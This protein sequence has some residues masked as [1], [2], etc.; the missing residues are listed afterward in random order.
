MYY[1]DNTHDFLY[2][3]LYSIFIYYVLYLYYV[4]LHPGS[5]NRPQ[6]GHLGRLAAFALSWHAM[7]LARHYAF[8]RKTQVTQASHRIETNA[9]ASHDTMRDAS[10]KSRQAVRTFAESSDLTVLTGMTVRAGGC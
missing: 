7:H 3:V 1:L 8:K 9:Q 5:A 4:F 6:T 10:R 2:Y